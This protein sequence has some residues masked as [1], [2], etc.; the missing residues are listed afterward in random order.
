MPGDYSTAAEG[1]FRAALSHSNSRT[2]AGALAVATPNQAAP[3][4]KGGPCTVPPSS[5]KEPSGR[6]VIEPA[7]L[8]AQ[9]KATP[10]RVIWLGQKAIVAVCDGFMKMMRR[11]TGSSGKTCVGV[12]ESVGG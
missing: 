5:T 8:T 9:A 12:A 4:A 2:V 11:R 6:S 10:A 1:G 7:P 3:I